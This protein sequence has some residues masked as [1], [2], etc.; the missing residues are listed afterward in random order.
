MNLRPHHL[1][2]IQKYQGYGYSPAFTEHM[3]HITN[4]LK[5]TP[6]TSV[7]LVSKC[8][9]ICTACPNCKARR[10]TEAQ[11]TASLDQAVM[12]ACHLA[13]H[14]VYSWKTLSQTADE[15]IFQTE[16]FQ[17]ICTCC[18]WYSLCKE[19]EIPYGTDC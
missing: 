3:N 18:E 12:T 7:Q 17:K 11:K 4:L 13:Y 14:Q 16:Q 19:R 8:D 2:C 10:C 15:M 6:E 1:L 5:R 9:D